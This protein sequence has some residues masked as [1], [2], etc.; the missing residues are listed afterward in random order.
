MLELAKIISVHNLRR[1]ISTCN[2][3]FN[4]YAKREGKFMT[5]IMRGEQGKR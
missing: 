5:K 2:V 4:K 3:Y 1:G